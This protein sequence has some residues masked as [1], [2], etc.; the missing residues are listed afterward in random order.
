MPTTDPGFRVEVDPRVRGAYFR[1]VKS[2]AAT[3][4]RGIRGRVILPEVNFDPARFYRS[5]N[6]LDHFQT[7]PLDR[8][9][10]YLG[11]HAGAHEVDAGLSWDRVYDAQG[12]PTYTDLPRGTDGREPGHIFARTRI[13]GQPAI[14]DGTGLVVAEGKDE[15][16]GRMAALRPNFA[17]RPFWRTT[18]GGNQWHNPRVRDAQ[19]V[20][21]YPGERVSMAVEE[22]GPNRMRLETR[23][24]G[25]ASAPAFSRTFRQ[26]GFGRG[27]PQSFKRVTAIDQF[28]VDARG[29]RVGVEGRDVL[30]TRTVAIGCTWEEVY[31]VAPG[32]VKSQ[33]VIGDQF[34]NVRGGDVAD[35]YDEIFRCSGWDES[36]AERI[37]IVPS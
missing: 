26:D 16:E 29:R 22:A 8:P 3:E 13:A 12:R 28:T 4:H 23:G 14:L 36:G 17:F 32:G 21:F 30:P 34:V 7:G 27:E 10:I 6:G 25:R 9:S 1:K 37:D 5:P 15:V 18:N 24:E 33:A 19:N 35:R 20:Y 31:L 2:S 11:G